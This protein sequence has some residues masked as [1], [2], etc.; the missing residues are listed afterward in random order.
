M[1]DLSGCAGDQDTIYAQGLGIQCSQSDSWI[2]DR[3]CTSRPSGQRVSRFC[4][5]TIGISNCFDSPD[6]DRKNQ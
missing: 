2:A 1:A 6:S 3:A 4:Y 5:A